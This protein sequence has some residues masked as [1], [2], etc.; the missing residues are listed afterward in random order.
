MQ[1]GSTASKL[2]E[3]Q[4]MTT[5]GVDTGFEAQGSPAEYNKSSSHLA[6]LLSAGLAVSKLPWLEVSQN[7]LCI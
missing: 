6:L 5:I 2:L 1:A 3:S 7:L 4:D